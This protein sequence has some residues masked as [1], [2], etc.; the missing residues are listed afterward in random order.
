MESYW[1][2]NTIFQVHN[3]HFLFVEPKLHGVPVLRVIPYLQIH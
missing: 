2:I 3:Y 1:Y